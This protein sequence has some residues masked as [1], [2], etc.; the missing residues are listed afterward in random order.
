LLVCL[1]KTTLEELPEGRFGVFFNGDSYIVR[2]DYTT[3]SNRKGVALYFWQGR[4]SEVLEKGSAA[5][6][7]VDI[8][9]AITVRSPLHYTHYH[10]TIHTYMCWNLQDTN[11]AKSQTR[12]VQG[13]EP[14]DFLH[15]F[16]GKFAVFQGGSTDAA[17]YSANTRL[18]HIKSV[19]GTTRT[20]EM[21]ATASN[22]NSGDA[23]IVVPEGANADSPT[24]VYVWFGKGTNEAER[25]TA[26]LV[27]ASVKTN[28]ALGDTA[29][30]LEEGSEPEEFWT[31]LG[32]MQHALQLLP[33]NMMN[34]IHGLFG[35]AGKAEYVE[36]PSLADDETAHLFQVSDMT[37]TLRVSYI[38]T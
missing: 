9:A 22:L 31:A 11:T 4:L 37:G 21:A 24:P 36:T 29:T 26:D 15:L 30:V 17:D 32:G 12:V 6:T 38:H 23:F 5:K 25:S 16:G 14:A 1:Q 27:L 3:R 35:H 28:L 2:H 10:M 8:A 20:I 19:S 34:I 33:H 18:F 13:S 7:V